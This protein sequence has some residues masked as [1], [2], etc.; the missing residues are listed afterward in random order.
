MRSLR[1]IGTESSSGSPIARANFTTGPAL[2]FRRT[3]RRRS[4]AAFDALT[5]HISTY[6]VDD[7]LDQV[8][9]I[10]RRYGL[11]VSI[12]HLD[13]CRQNENEKQI[14][15]SPLKSRA[16]TARRRPGI[17]RQRG[18][19]A[20]R[21]V[22]TAQSLYRSSARGLAE[23]VKGRPPNPGTCGKLNPGLGKLVDFIGA[24]ILT[25]LGRNLRSTKRSTGCRRV[26]EC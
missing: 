20:R 22:G 18:H 6:S 13:W 10:A 16:R 17:R 24:H 23:R 1:P 21:R 2:K 8:P 5:G 11:M 3:N 14:S 12:G 25:L 9:E 7:G 4:Q 15:P 26:M 19:I